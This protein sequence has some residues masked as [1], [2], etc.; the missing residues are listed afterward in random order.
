MTT[1]SNAW[2]YTWDYRNR[3]TKA[4]NGLATS[5]HKYDH[6]NARVAY[7]DTTAAGTATHY[8]DRHHSKKQGTTTISAYVGD[9]LVGTME[10]KGTNSI[11][12]YVHTDHLGSVPTG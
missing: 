9:M 6:D 3:L 1:S 5:T 10:N 2:N 4:E 12:T 8:G 11:I 7:N